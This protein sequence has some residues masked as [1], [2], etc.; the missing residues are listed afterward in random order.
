MQSSQEKEPVFELL[1]F[2]SE[3]F[4]SPT[5]E[6]LI[7]FLFDCIHNIRHLPRTPPHL[8]SLSKQFVK[9]RRTNIKTCL[10]LWQISCAT[11]KTIEL[12][13][14]FKIEN[15]HYDEAGKNICQNI[16]HIR[17]KKT[18]RRQKEKK[19][20]RQKKTDKINGMYFVQN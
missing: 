20:E 4:F 14:K 1:P 3:G 12:Q 7:N 13:E 6:F 18:K 5:F 8:I 19:N 15:S 17:V 2:C 10:K 16:K 11:S 9:C